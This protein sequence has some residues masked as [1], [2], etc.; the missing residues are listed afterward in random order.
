MTKLAAKMRG[1]SHATHGTGMG[2]RKC[3]RA[4]GGGPFS[5]SGGIGGLFPISGKEYHARLLVSFLVEV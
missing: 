3:G 1:T 4:G 5:I 2:G